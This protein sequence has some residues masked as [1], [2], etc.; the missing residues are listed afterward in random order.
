[1]EDPQRVPD[2]H[3]RGRFA[4]GFER[5]EEGAVRL[6]GGAERK[7]GGILADRERLDSSEGDAWEAGEGVEERSRF[8]GAELHHAGGVTAGGELRGVHERGVGG[9]ETEW[10]ARDEGVER[11]AGGADDPFEDKHA[12]TGAQG[13]CEVGREHGV[14]DEGRGGFVATE[15]DGIA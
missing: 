8:P 15:L 12:T 14:D 4:L 11:G 2:G 13:V 7:R 9:I 3:D 1:M 5:D 6:E 10:S